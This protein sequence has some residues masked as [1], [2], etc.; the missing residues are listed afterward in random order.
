MQWSRHGIGVIDR[1]FAEG[2]RLGGEAQTDNAK[3][4]GGAEASEGSA[5]ALAAGAAGRASDAASPGAG[6]GALCCRGVQ[7]AKRN[8]TSAAGATGTSAT[9]YRHEASGFA[10]RMVTDP[11]SNIMYA[12][13]AR[14]I[15]IWER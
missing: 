5:T 3:S 11:T 13:S 10:L 12:S 14:P 9:T 1:G 6:A 8:K 2:L 15:S 4:S 7:A